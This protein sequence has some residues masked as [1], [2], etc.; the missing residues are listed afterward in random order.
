MDGDVLAVEPDGADGYFVAGDFTTVGGTAQATLA[1]LLADGSVDLAFRP[2]I[3]G[4]VRAIARLGATLYV[5]GSIL[6]IGGIF[7]SNAGA[8]SV[9]DGTRIGWQPATSAVPLVSGLLA[10]DDRIVISGND[11][12]PMLSSGVVAAYD[13]IS[14]A[15]LW[16]TLVGPGAIGGPRGSAGQMVRAGAR[17]IVAHSP[18]GANGG[19]SNLALA[20]GAV[21][22]A[23][24]PQVSPSA[25]VLSGTTL[26]LGGFFTTV[27]G[28]PRLSL[29][30]IDVTTAT[31]L[32]WNPGS[33]TP[34]LRMG[35]SSGG[36]FV[37]GL[38]ETIGGQPRHRLAQIDAAGAVTPWIADARPDN[39]YTLAPGP[40]GTLVASS[41]LSAFGN[42]ARSRLAAFDLAT[43][44]LLPW[45]PA[46]DRSVSVIGATAGRVTA[47]GAFTTIDGQPAVGG[48]ALDPATGARL[49]SLPGVGSFVDDTW[50]Y[51]AAGPG[52]SGPY[53]LQRYAL[54]T[55]TGDHGW[56][57]ALPGSPPMAGVA[58]GHTLFLAAGTALVAVDRRTAQV[59]WVNASADVRRLTL[60][61]D[62]LFTDGGFT[63][64]TTVD[65]RTGQVIAQYPA[66]TGFSAMTVADGRVIVNGSEEATL[67]FNR[68][69]MA[70]RFDG[71][72]AAWSPGLRPTLIGGPAETF[73]VAGDR[74]VAGGIFGRRTAP[75]LQGLAVFPLDGARAPAGLRARPKGAATEFT[76]DQT[77]SAPTGGYV[78]EAS[79]TPGQPIV[80]LP[81]GAATSFATVVPSGTFYVRVRA[82]GAA[83]GQDE[84]SN[85]IAVR[86]GCAGLPAP[87]TGLR[88]T[89][90]GTLVTLSWTAPDALVDRYLL[91]V[92]TTSGQTNLLTATIDGSQTS[93]AAAAPPATYYVRARAVNACGTSAPSG[94]VALTVGASDPLPAA[95]SGLTAAVSGSTVQFA[96][97][98]PPGPVSGY[99]L[100]AGLDVGLATLGSFPVGATPAMTVAGVPPGVYLVRVRALNGAGSGPPSLDVVVRVP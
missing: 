33:L 53:T 61:G 98:A 13:P 68:R 65:A 90:V 16:T 42:V 40:A 57:L 46:A 83:S 45:A 64:L 39:V 81:L 67:G 60:S 30:A 69:P 1:H 92:G 38:F 56:Q 59:R 77:V 37:T 95:P 97:T 44:A 85:E 86:G 78:L 26:Y 21:D 6:S 18:S 43:G 8:V 28:Q 94:E 36:V 11:A 89:I 14:G 20:T 73:D 79:V 93:F 88:A 31:L 99:V 84:L 27:A 17:V 12:L 3:V 24:N 22:A 66:P 23:W 72:A 55:G 87:P 51:W 29:A 4:S 76:W 35:A 63:M 47:T 100:E 80:A 15:E 70:R 82:V 62:T 7:S 96:W 50:I 58:D 52:P 32:P 9:V 25:L 48:V 54:D 19:L 2:Q 41:S 49:P 10:A 5:G 91:D 34:I 71:T 75:A 74:L